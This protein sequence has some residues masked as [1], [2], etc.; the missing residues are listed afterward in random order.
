MADYWKLYK[1][2]KAFYFKIGSIV[3]PAMD[4]E[5]I[6]FDKRGFRHIL[7]KNR[8]KRPIPDQIRR[9]KM[10]LNIKKFLEFA[11]ID[12]SND[13]NFYRLKVSYNKEKFKIVI[14]T[15]EKGRKYFVSIM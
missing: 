6:F 3:C 4:N 15:N 13:P 9:L 12:K 1:K 10:I 14:M 2:V 8:R 11:Q 5:P 7:H